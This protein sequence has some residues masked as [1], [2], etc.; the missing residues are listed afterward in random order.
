MLV[1]AREFFLRSPCRPPVKILTDANSLSEKIEI[2]SLRVGP[3]PR[4][5]RKARERSQ[6][7]LF[8]LYVA[9][10]SREIVLRVAGNARE[11]VWNCQSVKAQNVAANCTVTA[12]TMTEISIS[13]KFSERKQRES[14][15]SSNTIKVG[16]PTNFFRKW[17]I[18]VIW[19]HSAETQIPALSWPF[20]LSWRS[21]I[22]LLCSARLR[23]WLSIVFSPLSN[24]SWAEWARIV[25]EVN[26]VRLSWTNRFGCSRCLFGLFLGAVTEPLPRSAKGVYRYQLKFDDSNAWA[27]FTRTSCIEH[28]V[29]WRDDELGAASSVHISLEHPVTFVYKK[30]HLHVSFSLATKANEKADTE[31]RS[32]NGGTKLI[33]EHLKRLAEMI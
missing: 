6:K 29:E 7:R 20:E 17:F 8:V 25:L 3:W 12:N 22:R 21:L 5:R 10:N 14:F 4:H 27:I 13:C 15:A 16:S 9:L 19:R 26:R 1:Q 18:P 2:N 32:D 31:I 24:K 33:I 30:T 23:L 28:L 11:L